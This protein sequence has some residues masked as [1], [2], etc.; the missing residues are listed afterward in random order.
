MRQYYW[1][2]FTIA[3][4]FQEKLEYFYNGNKKHNRSK[5][6]ENKK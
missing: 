3:N 5:T 2:K 6:Y 1:K 4:F